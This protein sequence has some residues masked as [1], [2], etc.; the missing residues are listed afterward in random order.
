M[1]T[2]GASLSR[3][4]LSGSAVWPRSGGSGKFVSVHAVA[5]DLGIGAIGGQVT[6]PTRHEVEDAFA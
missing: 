2:A 5:D 4:G 3:S 6:D 1:S